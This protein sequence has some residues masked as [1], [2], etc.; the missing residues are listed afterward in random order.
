MIIRAL[1]RHERGGADEIDQREALGEGHGRKTLQLL[2]R[3]A[4]TQ[5]KFR[6]AISQSVDVWPCT[7]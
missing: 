5:R 7:Q 2:S 4:P 6:D 3:M 1:Q